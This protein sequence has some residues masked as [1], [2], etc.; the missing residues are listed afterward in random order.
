MMVQ[1]YQRPFFARAFRPGDEHHYTS[2]LILG[3]V[4]EPKIATPTEP[5][6][7]LFNKISATSQAVRLVKPLV[8]PIHKIDSKHGCTHYRP[9]S[10]SIAYKNHKVLQTAASNSE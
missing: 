1:W 10:T 2:I 6:A 8:I 5:L 7:C 3:F 4:A 9:M